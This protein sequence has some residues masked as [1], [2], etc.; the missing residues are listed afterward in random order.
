MQSIGASPQL[1]GDVGEALVWENEGSERGVPGRSGRSLPPIDIP[2]V[3]RRPAPP[4]ARPPRPLAPSQI[5]EDR[6]RAP[7]PGPEMR[8]AARRGSLLHSLFER[9][10][11]VAEEA[12]RPLALRWLERAGIEEAAAREEIAEAALAIIADPAFADLFE[13]DAL[14]EAPIVATLADGRVV[15]GTVDRLR[16]E[17]GRIRLVDFKTGRQVPSGPGQVPAAHRAQMEAYVEALKIIFPGRRIDASL[18]Y[19]SGPKL[20]DLGG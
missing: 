13:P 20:I 19:T 8:E 10:P 14:A 7:P 1:L 15:A 18:L 12:R 3:L 11:S 9:L 5:V 16:I 6:D 4:E 17:A 2:D